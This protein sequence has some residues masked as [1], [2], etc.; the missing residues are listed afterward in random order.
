LAW[1]A[2]A[3]VAFAL[4]VEGVE[5]LFDATINTSLHISIVLDSN[6][7]VKSELNGGSERLNYKLLCHYVSYPFVGYQ[8]GCCVSAL[9]R[10]L[11]SITYREV[12]QAD[13]ASFCAT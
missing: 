5:V 2:T 3:L 11:N 13:D 10:Y 1:T 12:C 9:T 6:F 4:F 7:N 8:V